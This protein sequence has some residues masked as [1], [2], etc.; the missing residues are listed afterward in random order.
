MVYDVFLT[1]LNSH[2]IDDTNS[3]IIL[4]LLQNRSRARELTITQVANDCF[5]SPASITR[6]IQRFGFLSFP[7]LKKQISTETGSVDLTSFQLSSKDR[8]DAATDAAVY[9]SNYGTHVWSSIKTCAETLSLDDSLALI[10]AIEHADQVYLFGYDSILDYLKRFQQSLVQC[11]IY[12]FLSNTVQGQVELAQRMTERDL[13]I[14]SSSFGQFFSHRQELAKAIEGS[15]AQ[16]VL[17]TQSPA[18]FN[19]IE[20]DRTIV[21]TEKPDPRAGSFCMEFYLEFLARVI[22]SHHTERS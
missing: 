1:Y 10:E 21:I 14:I 8:Q 20:M 12:A 11:E 9:L 4:Y 22:C 3:R 19:A 18:L 6:F 15:G 2:S 7:E 5:V 13:C 16:T 17:L